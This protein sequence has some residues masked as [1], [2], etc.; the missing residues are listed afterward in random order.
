MEFTIAQYFHEKSDKTASESFTKGV[1]DVMR[2]VGLNPVRSEMR[3]N[4]VSGSII[5][6]KNKRC[7]YMEKTIE[8]LNNHFLGI[9][10]MPYSVNIFYVDKPLL[11]ELKK[12]SI[13]DHSFSVAWTT[14][15]KG[16]VKAFNI[17]LNSALKAE[18]SSFFVTGMHE[19]LHLFGMA[20]CKADECVLKSNIFYGYHNIFQEYERSKK[21]PLCIKHS[22]YLTKILRKC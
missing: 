1:E 17:L 9:D 7:I 8:G 14:D 21:I 4:S 20:H 10:F 2:F 19:F 22:D 5:Y 12:D 16:P 6:S 13:N 11:H 18:E 15:N 3:Y